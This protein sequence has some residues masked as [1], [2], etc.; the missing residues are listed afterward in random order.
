LIL[1]S[2]AISTAFSA[3]GVAITTDNFDTLVKGSN[4]VWAIEIFSEMCGSCK[5]FKPVWKE[6]V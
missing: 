1:I 6:V 4:D 2:L 3:E 5:E